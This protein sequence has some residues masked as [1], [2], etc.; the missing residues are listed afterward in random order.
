MNYTTKSGKDILLMAS[1]FMNLLEVDS[2]TEEN[3]YEKWCEKIKLVEEIK[4][5]S[6]VTE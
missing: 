6:E 1:F 2:I 5:E 4:K 3:K